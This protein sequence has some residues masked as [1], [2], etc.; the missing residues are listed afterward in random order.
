MQKANFFT[1]LNARYFFS[2]PNFQKNETMLS[3]K[4]RSLQLVWHFYLYD[5]C[6]L[7]WK[8]LA[9]YVYAVNYKINGMTCS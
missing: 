7:K 9:Q 8:Q 6:E 2:E 3:P 5:D 1:F 4:R